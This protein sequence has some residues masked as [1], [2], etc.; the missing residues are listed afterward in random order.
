MVQSFKCVML[1]DSGVGK[2]SLLTRF[3]KDAFRPETRSTIS[4]AFLERVVELADGESVRLEIW[5]TAGQERFRSLNTPM[6]Y[7]GAAAA[8]LAYDATDAESFAHVPGWFSQL[9]MMGEKG[10]CVA[11]VAS[12]RDLAASVAGRRAVEEAAGAKFAAERGIAVFRETSAKSGENVEDFFVALGTELRDRHRR[13][14]GV[15]GAA[16]G[17]LKIT[18]PLGGAKK[19]S[20]GCR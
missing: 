1:G 12:K 5:D 3:V 11:L 8:V 18:A 6:Y 20:C 19:R 15:G 17:A 9:V 10:C 7:R 14:E 2:T 13:G 16:N 4:A